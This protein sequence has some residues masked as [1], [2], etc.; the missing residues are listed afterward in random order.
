MY[1]IR[2]RRHKQNQ[3]NTLHHPHYAQ[4]YLY[5]KYCI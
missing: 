5:C 4:A 2:N 3:N 1:L